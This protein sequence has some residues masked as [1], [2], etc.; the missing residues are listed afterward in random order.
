VWPNGGERPPSPGRRS[1]RAEAGGSLIREAPGRAGAA[2]TTTG[3][4]STTGWRGSGKRDGK[5]YARNR[6]VKPLKTGASSNPVDVGWIAVRT[7]L[8]LRAGNFLAG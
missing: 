4:V 2:P 7:R 1:G 3:R 8:S 5:V 6:R